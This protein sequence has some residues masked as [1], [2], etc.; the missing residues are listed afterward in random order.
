MASIALHINDRSYNNSHNN[1]SSG[2]AIDTGNV[3]F[4][5]KKVDGNENHSEKVM[6]SAAVLAAVLSAVVALALIFVVA[7]MPT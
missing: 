5:T 6:A 4:V 3:T 7:V 2:S 1:S